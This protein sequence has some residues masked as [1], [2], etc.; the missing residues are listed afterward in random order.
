MPREDSITCI[1]D[2]I[3]V[4]GAFEPNKLA[5]SCYFKDTQSCL[6][7]KLVPQM[8]ASTLR[9]GSIALGATNRAQRVSQKPREFFVEKYTL[10]LTSLIT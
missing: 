6:C 5:T 9:A 8:S 10:A 1:S 2:F 3:P 4:H 7:E